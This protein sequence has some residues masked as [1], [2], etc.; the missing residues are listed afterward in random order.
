MP[1]RR[2]TSTYRLQ[3]HSGFTFRDA[4]RIVPY[5]AD[6]GVSHLYLSPILEAVPGSMHGYD[7]V[8][9]TN[10]SADLGGRDALLSLA[11]RA[12]GQGLGLICDVVPNHMAIPAPEHLNRQLWNVLQHGQQAESA[13]WFDIDWGLCGGRLGLP[14]LDDTLE[15][16]LAAGE[17]TLDK[18]DG[19]P[20]LR[21]YDHVFPIAP[22][23]ENDR[24]DEPN[25]VAD[26]L[27]RQHYL[28]ASWREKDAVLGY[29]R[30]F[31]V[32][33]L[34]AVRIEQ[35]EV[36][37]ATHA[38][39]LELY[40]DDVLDGFRIDHPDGLVDPEAY[41]TQ[42][43][44]A[45][46]DGWVVV[47]KILEGDE[48]LPPSWA[49]AGST[50]YDALN[51][52]Q[53]ALSPSSVQRLDPLWQQ[54][55][56]P[57]SL[58]AT[59]QA[60]KRQVLTELLRPELDRIVRLAVAAA[61][62]TGVVV[63][64][65]EITAAVEELLVHVEVYRAYVRL[66]RPP[67]DEALARLDHMVTAAAADRPGLAEALAVLR[68]LLT[69]VDTKSAA[70]RDLVVRFQ[71]V[72][73]PVMAKGVEDTT[74]YRWN[75]LI[76]LNEVGGDPAAL[77]KPGPE[78]LHAWATYQQRHYPTG[79]T[80][81][82]THDTKRSEDVRARLLAI[83]GHPDAWGAVW[84]EVSARAGEHVVD[85]PTAYL[86]FQTLLGAWPI[87][88]ERFC[89]YVVKAIREAKR[90]TTWDDPDESYEGRV[91]ALARDCLS[92][93][94]LNRRIST[95]LADHEDDIASVT[96]GAKLL[97][98]TLPGVPDVYQG[99]ERVVLSLVDPDNRGPV[100]YEA[101]GPGFVRVGDT[102]ATRLQSDE[103]LNSAKLL[104]TAR[105]LRL[106]RDRPWL[107]GRDAT[108]RPL[109]CSPELIAFARTHGDDAVV[110]VVRRTGG[111]P[112]MGEVT[113]SAGHWTDVFTEHLYGGGVTQAAELLTT[114]P[115]ALL[116]K[117]GE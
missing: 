94:T 38:L 8:D 41:L 21:Y 22:G 105:A 31:D 74:F 57:D 61:Q 46:D 97:Q 44:D 29:R 30:F 4:E 1:D 111:A 68:A 100:D 3:L 108:Y 106:R 7:V 66:G 81:L 42:L 65:D 95:T 26:I 13:G 103:S 101:H 25:T 43:R 23:T 93:T 45:T 27:S 84:A 70:G 90:H 114:L 78:R 62:Q 54:V 2:L 32:D 104:V 88:E 99:C 20:V 72:C 116:V 86:L 19:E 117:D 92:A 58:A 40:S 47:E 11:D 102:A 16:T 52:I 76:A 50:G 83:A 37:A 6:L 53:A 87:D 69:D 79:M 24:T 48:R 49:T 28:L 5:L 110:T 67:D 82:S 17:I 73:G 18:H 75:R 10:I 12:H 112:G 59:E 55:A 56:G 9:H 77:D 107:F 35:P 96:L 91:L 115:V 39:L 80:T 71:Q 14:L 15:R 98:L 89:A 60:A 51:V 109:P 34:I 36:F 113:L 33:T 63:E 85:G 64:P